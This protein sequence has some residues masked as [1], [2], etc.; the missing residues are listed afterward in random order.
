MMRVACAV[1]TALF[2]GLFMSTSAAAVPQPPTPTVVSY[3]DMGHAAR[4]ART[5]T[6]RGPPAS[7]YGYTAH[8]AVDP[9]SDGTPARPEGITTC[10]YTTYDPD[11]QLV[12]VDRGHAVARTA[13]GTVNGEAR[14]VSRSSVAAKGGSS[15][16]GDLAAAERHLASIPDA[17]EY[18]PNRA[19][20]DSIRSANTAGR[21]L[22]AAERTFLDHE[23]L[24]AQLVR[25]GLSQEAAHASVLKVYPP[26][27][28]YSPEVIKEFS[29]H[30]SDAYFQYWGITR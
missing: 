29:D 21:P 3:D 15:I 19:M 2:S 25:G 7:A 30:F 14:L 10:G 13:A 9:G 16:A 17:L 22:T 24:E 4:V 1:I 12:R 27:S 20:L 18:G 11:A 6:E 8:G 28:N 23:L 26:G 5:T